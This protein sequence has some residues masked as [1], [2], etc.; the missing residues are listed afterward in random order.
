MALLIC[1]VG[2]AAFTLGHYAAQSETVSPVAV[3][4]TAGIVFV[5][6]PATTTTLD[7]TG[8]QIQVVASRSGTK[9]HLLT[10]SGAKTIKA[11]NKIYFDSIDQAKAAGYEPAANCRGLK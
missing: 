7:T 4:N 3:E 10:C 5:D 8:E 1:V 6:A 9:Y 2:I 11:S